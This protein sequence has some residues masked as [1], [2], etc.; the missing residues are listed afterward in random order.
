MKKYFIDYQTGAGN[1]SIK[2]TLEEAIETAIKG[3]RYT[4]TSITITDDNDNQVATLRWYGVSPDVDEVEEEDIA[5]RFGDFGYYTI[6][7]Y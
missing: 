2:G 5:V 7:I 4:Q 3:A 6:E 1:Q